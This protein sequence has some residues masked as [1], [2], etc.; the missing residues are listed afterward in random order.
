[1]GRY[2]KTSDSVN[3]PVAD[4]RASVFAQQVFANLGGS[5]V[6]IPSKKLFDTEKVE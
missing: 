2:L 1:M 4:S 3:K 6:Y 5:Q